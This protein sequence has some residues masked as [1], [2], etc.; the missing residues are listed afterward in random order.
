MKQ[1]HIY[2]LCLL[3]GP[4]LEKA[5][6]KVSSYNDKMAHNKFQMATACEAPTWVQ[7][8]NYGTNILTYPNDEIASEENRR[9]LSIQSA[10]VNYTE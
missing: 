6:F 2:I 7:N 3:S 1:I 10:T 4:F 5:N 9:N 8:A